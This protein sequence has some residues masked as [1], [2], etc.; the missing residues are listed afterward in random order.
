MATLG[1][2]FGFP[3]PRG[4][5]APLFSN[6]FSFCSNKYLFRGPFIFERS[7]IMRTFFRFHHRS[8]IWTDVWNEIRSRR[9]RT[10]NS[11]KSKTSYLN[12]RLGINSS[13]KRNFWAGAW[14]AANQLFFLLHSMACRTPIRYADHRSRPEM[15]VFVSMFGRGGSTVGDG[16]WRRRGEGGGTLL[17]RVRTIVYL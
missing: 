16:W 1:R 17:K 8:S 4:A 12:R 3:A 11:Y 15:W 13:P 9:R 7:L 14:S 10:A 6:N 5:I 2:T